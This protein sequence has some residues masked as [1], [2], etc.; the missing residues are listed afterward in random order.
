[1]KAIIETGNK[2]YIV[3]EGE[4][5]SIERL[6][7][8]EKKIIFEKILAI[9]EEGQIKH[10]NPYLKNAVVEGEILGEEKGEKVIAYKYRRRT[11]SHWKRG[12]RQ[13]YTK[14]KIV[15]ILEKKSGKVNEG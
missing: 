7:V 6:D 5:I 15:R 12:H 2:Q 1:M 14:V 8:P 13:R 11:D 4:I 9:G 3:K 10:G